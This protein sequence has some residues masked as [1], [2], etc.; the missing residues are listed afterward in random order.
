METLDHITHTLFTALMYEWQWV[1]LTLL[2]VS[3]WFHEKE[4][5][6][7]RRPLAILLVFGS[8]ISMSLE[9]F[10]DSTFLFWHGHG[11]TVIDTCFLVAWTTSLVMSFM[12]VPRVAMGLTWIPLF[13]TVELL[14]EGGLH[15]GGVF[16]SVLLGFFI[17]FLLLWAKS[18]VVRFTY[19]VEQLF[20]HHASVMYPFALLVLL[21]INQDLVFL[22][23]T[24]HFMFGHGG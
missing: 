5:V 10:I 1:L 24:F 2:P 11:E 8:A 16:F 13:L 20:M 6:F 14:E 17:A 21:D 18:R 23:A 19:G 9:H 3:F 4:G 22:D 12:V 7:A 15:I